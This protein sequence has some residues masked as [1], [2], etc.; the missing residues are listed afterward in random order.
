MLVVA[1]LACGAFVGFAAGVLVTCL[2]WDAVELNAVADERGKAPPVKRQ[3][4][5]EYYHQHQAGLQEMR[6]ADLARQD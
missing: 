4:P 5:L 6:Q 1:A 3:T 2:A